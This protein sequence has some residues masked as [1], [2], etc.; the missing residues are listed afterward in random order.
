M[1]LVR[2]QYGTSAEVECKEFTDAISGK[3]EYGISIT[4]KETSRLERKSSSYIDYDE[5]DSLLKGIDYIAKIEKSIT[6]LSYF[7]ANYS[8]KGELQVSTY[9]DSGGKVQASVA[10]GRFGSVGTFL[11][12][13]ELAEFKRLIQEAKSKLDSIR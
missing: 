7:Q 5:I 12:L 6:K 13:D 8:T 2:G 10:S 3:K 11:S 4:V 9:S 1:G